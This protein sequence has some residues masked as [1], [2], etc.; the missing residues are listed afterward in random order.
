VTKGEILY[1][2]GKLARGYTGIPKARIRIF[3]HDRSFLL[4]AAW[5]DGYTKEDGTFD[6]T[7]KAKPPHF[8]NDTA[9]LYAE[10]DDYKEPKRIRSEVQTITIK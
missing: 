8:W 2:K 4:D 3:E 7:A 5:A 10:Y 9:K 6:L 1:F